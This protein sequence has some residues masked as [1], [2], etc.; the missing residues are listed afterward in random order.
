MLPF[1]YDKTKNMKKYIAECIGTF[2]LV[3]CGTG[4][5]IV[6][7]QGHGE[8]GLIGI[9]IAFGVV[10]MAVIY[11][12]GNISGAHINPAVT[13]ALGIGKLISKNDMF[14]YI[15][16]Q[17]TGAFIASGLLFLMFPE[18]KTFGETIPSRGLL[19]SFVL[20][21][22]LTF[23]L[24]LTILGVTSK[25]ENTPLAGIVI[26]AVVTGFILVSG[27]VS[28]GSFNPARSIAPA[29]FSKNVSSLW[30]YIIAPIGG[31][32]FSIVIWNALTKK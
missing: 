11:S 1:F 8:L 10:I 24:M 32:S 6:N 7:Q 21:F 12:L 13:I 27:P 15:V 25:K 26:G 16:A 5:V 14:G 2:A 19:S 22:V 31:A 30:L 9:S 23:F 29:F 3:F 28:G 17:I 18:T 20:E 4:S